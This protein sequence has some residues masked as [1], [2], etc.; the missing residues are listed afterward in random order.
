[1]AYICVDQIA[2]YAPA[3]T[4]V[5]TEQKFPAGTKV[6]GFDA[7]LGF[8][9]FVYLKGLASTAVGELV[10]FDESGVTTRATTGTRGPCA[11][12]LYANTSATQWSWYQVYGV[13]VGKTATVAAD[14]PVY[15]TATAGT[16]DDAVSA[17]NKVDGAITMT[18]D[19]A[20][21]TTV[22]G[23]VVN[24]AGTKA[25]A[26]YTVAAGTALVHLSYPVMNGNG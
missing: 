26:T 17:T 9:E 8:G 1:M 12:A 10:K 18:A 6:R 20:G 16:M 3:L 23:F 7:A 2:G 11:I 5:D 14:A 21:S 19:G 24:Q 25:Q 15:A 13:A 22:A 4:D